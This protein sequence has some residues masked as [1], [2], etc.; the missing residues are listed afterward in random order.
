MTS[1]AIKTVTLHTCSEC[2]EHFD[3]RTK[4]TGYVNRCVDC[5]GPDVEVY[6]GLTVYANKH[7]RFLTLGKGADI[8][9]KIKQNSRRNFGVITSMVERKS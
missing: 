1:R 5:D 7:D 9:H 3:P 2:G 6:Q 4:P 8:Q